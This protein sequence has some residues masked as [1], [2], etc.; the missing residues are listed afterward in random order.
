MGESTDGTVAT[1]KATT[2]MECPECGRPMRLRTAR[3]GR[4]AGGHFWGCTGYPECTQTSPFEDTAAEP[5]IGEGDKVDDGRRSPPRHRVT[6]QDGTLDRAGHVCFHATAGASLRAVPDA[7]KAAFELS[8]CWIARP[9]TDVRPDGDTAR[10]IGLLRKLVQRG[11]APPIDPRAERMLL[12]RLGLR[13][14]LQRSPLPGDMSFRLSRR[15]P[16]ERLIEATCWEDPE[17]IVDPELRFDSEEERAFMSE[18]APRHLGATAARRLIPQA[19]LDAL[20]QGRGLASGGARRVDFLAVPPA[21]APFVVEIDGLQHEHAAEV[22]RERDN[23]LSQLDLEVVR[24]PAEEVRAGRGLALDEVVAR[25][26]NSKAPARL[27][28]VT[29]L[30]WAPVLL[31][32]AVLGLLEAVGSG[33]L[34]GERWVVAIDDP[35][36]V[37]ASLLPPYL[38]L[39]AAIDSLWGGTVMPREVVLVV[40]DEPTVWR[41]EGPAFQSAETAEE[42]G[43]SDVTIALEPDRGANDELISSRTGPVITVRSAHLP[44]Q[45]RDEFFE[46]EGRI[47]V[48]TEGEG[49]EA[50]LRTVLQAVFAKEDFRE[51]QLDA[52]FE[53]IEGR[54]CAVLLPTGGGK[55]LIYQLAGLCLPGRTL[56]IDPL[57]ALM[58]DQVDGLHSH[59]IDRVAML[60]SHETRLGR[61]EAILEDVKTGDALFVFV[62]PERLQQAL[63]RGALRALSHTTPI[64]L[65][66]VDEAHCVS[67]WGHDFRTSYLTLGRVLRDVCRDPSGRSAPILALTGTASR[68]VLR[69]VLIELAIERGSERAVVRPKTFDR[70]ELHFQIVHTEPRDFTAAL[71][72]FIRKLP[73]QFGERSSDFFR[74][75]GEG[76]SSG[77]VFCPHRSGPHGVVDIARTL[78]PVTGSP[79]PFY[80]GSPPRGFEKQDWEALKRRNADQ[81]KRNDSPLLVSTKAFGM[82]IDKP[83]IRYVVHV[84]IPQ[85]IESYYQ[86][87]GRAGRD[88]RSAECVLL[89]IEYDENRARRLLSDD[90][91]LEDT[92]VG[93][94]VR[95]NEADDVT[96]QLFFHL[97]AFRGVE[98]ELSDLAKL[99]SEVAK[100]GTRQTL[101]V[102][103]S[104]ER[105]KR[106]RAIHR[107]T[108]LGVVRD[109]LVDWGARKFTLELEHFDAGDVLQSLLR[110]IG[111]NQPGRVE[112]VRREIGDL[113]GNGLDDAILQCADALIGFV[114]DTVERSRRRSLR[115]MWLAARDTR[116]DPDRKFRMRILEYLS[117]GDIAPVLERLIERSDFDFAHWQEPLENVSPGEDARELRG[118]TARLLSS[119]PDH[120]G[121]LLARAL[122]EVLDDRGELREFQSNLTSALTSAKERYGTSAS[123]LDS[124]ARWLLELCR[125][126]PGATTAAIGAFERTRSCDVL[127]EQALA[128]ALTDPDA[129]V[130][131]RV[132]ALERSLQRAIDHISHATRTAQELTE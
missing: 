3:R 67:E 84:G 68:A 86:E 94:D 115:E 77:L 69:D 119:Y 44:V 127:V 64:N 73:S 18:W 131:L 36:D 29:T 27:D 54:D 62:T 6:W 132:M 116:D 105:D 108:V 89:L 124:L 114:Y 129:E 9:R 8:R 122:S 102:P 130:G 60:S 59:G 15:I 78:S 47:T 81:F 100:L 99:L 92:R 79:P 32:R 120:P 16:A 123:D 91:E 12:E 121:M 112:G 76:T 71:S 61:T 7:R 98:E 128:G 103:F 49:T 53:L 111:R 88:R 41:R 35:L 57:V 23:L 5:P 19:S 83:N 106:E 74:P 117:Q 22:D 1:G 125:R 90:A 28:T 37:V 97:Q 46:G 55:S 40:N 95:R 65:S 2:A 75:R 17:F 58:E 50:A 93:A 82:G 72:G 96:R 30:L 85:S 20:A 118:S 25:W 80:A 31:H 45:L 63:F 13:S 70:P 126:R 43:A 39:F 4:N 26:K 104:E 38:D 113:T 11:T 109:Y 51:G 101:E 52:I 33:L 42:A 24:I 21:A 56:V 48:R 66:V 34:A 10:V 87:V 107:L 14:D 110:Y